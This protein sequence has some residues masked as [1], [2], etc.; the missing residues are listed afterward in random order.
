MKNQQG[1]INYIEGL[2]IVRE[3]NVSGGVANVFGYGGGGADIGTHGG[4]VGNVDSYPTAGDARNV[5][6]SDV[7]KTDS[8]KKKKRKKKKGKSESK[9]HIYRRTFVEAMSESTE[10]QHT[11]NCL[12][13][14]ENEQYLKVISDILEKLSIAHKQDENAVLFEGT[15]GFLNHV[16]D[17]MCEVFTL[18]PFEQGE[19]VSFIGEMDVSS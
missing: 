3:M 10:S 6:G 5:F 18:E 4:S 12:L 7:S 15:D 14:T 2:K 1:N 11:L 17:Y 9:I 8:K 13:Y 16:I 19:I